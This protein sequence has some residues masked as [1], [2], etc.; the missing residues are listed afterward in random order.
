MNV[1]S[2][3]KSSHVTCEVCKGRI[4]SNQKRNKLSWKDIAV[5]LQEHENCF[6]KQININGLCCNRCYIS[7]KR[8]PHKHIPLKG[9]AEEVTNEALQ[10][11]TV[12][13]MKYIDPNGIF[14][15]TYIIYRTSV[16]SMTGSK[17]ILWK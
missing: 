11:A 10:N 17:K 12:I 2:H 4:K 14:T 13:E 7:I 6:Q 8:H 3:N 5:S 16:S 9:Q 15:I 1:Q